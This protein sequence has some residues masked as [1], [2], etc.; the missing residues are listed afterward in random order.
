M[1][2]VE[3]FIFVLF[4]IVVSFICLYN[5]YNDE[6]KIKSDVI[7]SINKNI[8]LISEYARN[9]NINFDKSGTVKLNALYKGAHGESNP[10]E[11]NYNFKMDNGIITLENEQGFVNY[12]LSKIYNL[13][14]TFSGIKS[15]AKELIVD[16][17][18]KYSKTTYKVDQYLIN[19]I[20][21]TNFSE[22][23][24]EVNTTGFI[25]K[26]K[27]YVIVLDDYKIST[28]KN[29]IVI[30]GKDNKIT[31]TTSNKGY[32]LNINDKLRVNVIDFYQ[33]NIFI[34]GTSLFME[35]TDNNFYLTALTTH[36]IY[37]ALEIT[38][39]YDNVSISKT[40]EAKKEE[41]PINRYFN[42]VD[43]DIWG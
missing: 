4:S 39:T 18:M 8:S 26:V 20:Y 17:D 23:L 33:Y 34:N 12:D 14:N 27:E 21:N 31:L 10:N 42:E 2:K 3:N 11:F 29:K 40:Q 15:F 5:I 7:D 41:N 32:S 13:I 30:Q 24:I 9:L 35:L 28:R 25:K 36:A 38:G 1:K 19:E 22:V 43:F 16:E 37:N 6:E